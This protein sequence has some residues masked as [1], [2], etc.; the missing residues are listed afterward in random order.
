V[1]SFLSPSWLEQLT[2]LAGGDEVG[3]GAT[4]VQHVVTGGPDG[5]IAFVLEIDG[6]RVRAQPGHD[7]R[8]VVTLTEDWDTALRLHRGELTARQAFL[9]GLI[10]V[11]GDVRRMVPAAS[12]LAALA[13][14]IATLRERTVGV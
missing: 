14:A 6:G 9:G 1:P 2:V 12:G 10:R 5:D 8:A 3:P 4:V 7:E 11:R 13:P